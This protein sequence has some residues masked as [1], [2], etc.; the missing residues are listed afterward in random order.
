M[1]SKWGSGGGLG[2]ARFSPKVTPNGDKLNLFNHSAYFNMSLSPVILN[3]AVTITPKEWGPGGPGGGGG[4]PYSGLNVPNVGGGGGHE[5][6]WFSI[7]AAARS[8]VGGGGEG[9]EKEGGAEWHPARRQL[10]GG[11]LAPQISF[12]EHK[13]EIVK[14][15]DKEA[16]RKA[17]PKGDRG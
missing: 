1:E 9:G 7:A 15:M 4:G 14:Q 8:G 12:L 16:A 5:K 6:P 3:G 2:D 17:I 13:L 10:E 11:D